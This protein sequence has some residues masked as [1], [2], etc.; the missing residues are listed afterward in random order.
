M[1][2]NEMLEIHVKYGKMIHILHVNTSLLMYW[3]LEMYH[4][5]CFGECDICTRFPFCAMDPRIL[6]IALAP[7]ISRI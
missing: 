1:R 2:I 6:N 7:G 5:M 4:Q 3:Y